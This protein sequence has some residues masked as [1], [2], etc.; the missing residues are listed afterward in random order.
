MREALH[1][2]DDYTRYVATEA[3]RNLGP[4]AAPAVSDLIDVI[5]DDFTQVGWSAVDTLGV[6]GSQAAEAIPVLIGLL[7]GEDRTCHSNAACAL[8]S[9]T[10]QDFGEGASAWQ[11]WFNLQ[12]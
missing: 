1:H 12:P 11:Q 3:L 7:E 8:E 4:E 9:I 10:G 2:S 6:I 5:G